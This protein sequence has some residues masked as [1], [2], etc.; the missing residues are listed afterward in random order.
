MTRSSS[1]GLKPRSPRNYDTAR[2]RDAGPLLP[3]TGKQF[4]RRATEKASGREAVLK[5]VDLSRNRR[6]Q[7]RFWDEALN[8]HNMSGTPG[9]LPVWDIDRTR[10]SEPRWYAMPRAQLLA[11]A[12][13]DEA[14]LRDV[15]GHIA[16]LAD[17]L[18][19]LT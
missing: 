8:M 9:I 5:H 18:A 2:W 17:V 15:V 7:P 10:P 1:R 3:G 14:T 16:F 4:V 6:Y 13:G 11:D 12:L 19:R